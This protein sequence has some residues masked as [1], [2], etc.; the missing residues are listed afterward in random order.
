MDTNRVIVV[1]QEFV[2]GL[3]KLITILDN[4]TT[5]IQLQGK[6]SS[7]DIAVIFKIINLTYELIGRT[8][9]SQ[10]DIARSRGV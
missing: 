4:N 2:D 8:I 6:H 7:E 9:D 5:V 1:T 3:E 10:I